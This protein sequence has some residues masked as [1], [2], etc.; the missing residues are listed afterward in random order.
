METSCSTSGRC[1]NSADNCNVQSNKMTKYRV[2]TIK[3]V[4]LKYSSSGWNRPIMA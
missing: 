2:F 1:M 4:G 3:V